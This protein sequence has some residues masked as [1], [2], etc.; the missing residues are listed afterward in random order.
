MGFFDDLIKN[1]DKGLKAIEDGALEE[2]LEKVADKLDKTTKKVEKTLGGAAD[3]PAQVLKVAEQK[4]DLLEAKAHDVK[5]HVGKSI[6]VLHKK[7]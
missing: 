4:K 5:E 2:R 3:K 7:D 1:V 6:D